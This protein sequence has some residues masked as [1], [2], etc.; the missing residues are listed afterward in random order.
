MSSKQ[1]KSLFYGEIIA[2]L[3]ETHGIKPKEAACIVTNSLERIFEEELHST[4]LTVLQE[5][6]KAIDIQKNKVFYSPDNEDGKIMIYSKSATIQLL[7]EL[8][9]KLE[10]LKK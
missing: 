6:E 4:R 3:I 10:E 9:A 2:C 1:E 5:V 8:R 7:D